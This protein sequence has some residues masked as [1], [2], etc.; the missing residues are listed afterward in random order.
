MDKRDHR[1]FCNLEIEVWRQCLHL[2]KRQKE[3]CFVSVKCFVKRWSSL[4]SYL[5]YTYKK[6]MNVCR[7]RFIFPLFLLF[8]IFVY[9]YSLTLYFCDKWTASLS[10]SFSLYVF[11]KKK[12]AI[13]QLFIVDIVV[14]SVLFVWCI[15]IH[16]MVNQLELIFF[17]CF[18]PDH[19]SNDLWKGSLPYIT[20]TTTKK[21]S[22]KFQKAHENSIYISKNK[23]IKCKPIQSWITIIIYI[24]RSS[25]LNTLSSSKYPKIANKKPNKKK[26]S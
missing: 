3:G 26:N 21:I 13:N 6:R 15:Y 23:N 18:D 17:S 19:I 16:K 2:N 4:Y 10:P 20:C 7:P 5:L 9:A 14:L 25:C 22:T 8:N 12:K 24:N 1:S 11:R